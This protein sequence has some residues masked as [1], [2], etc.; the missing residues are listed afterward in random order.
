MGTILDVVAE[1]LSSAGYD[2]LQ[3]RNVARAARVSLSTVYKHFPSRDDLV[4]AAVERWM[5][6][7][8]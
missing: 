6:E 4:I 5:A 7:N 2:G 1:Q 8:V 3:L